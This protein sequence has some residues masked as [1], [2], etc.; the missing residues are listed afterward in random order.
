MI[1]VTARKRSERALLA[2]EGRKDAVLR[3][4]LDCAVIVDHEGLVTEVNPATEETFGWTRADAVGKPFLDL[5]APEHR[6]DLGEIF[7]TGSSPLLGAPLEIAALRS[8]H[9]T[10]PAEVAI[11]RVDMTGELLFAI[12]LRDVTKRRDREE[13]LRE[14]EAKYRT[15]VE[16]IPLA[17]YIKEAGMPV[18]MRYMSPQI[19]RMLGYPVSDWLKP[20]FFLTRVHLDDYERVLAEIERTHN[21]GAD[22]RCEYRLV[23]A[24]GEPVWVLDETVAVRDAEY[25]PL[26]FQGFL[27]DVT[28][29]RR[30]ANEPEL[31]SVLDFDG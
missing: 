30:G 6:E 3:A 16:Q 25:R 14:A 28:D 12:S 4:S 20:D 19:E 21:G 31:V 9:R 11:T 10:F 27:V 1:D 8:D 18:R 23:G 29:R 22:F 2:S 7:A 24:D 5:V 17:T 13:R 26:F 15:L